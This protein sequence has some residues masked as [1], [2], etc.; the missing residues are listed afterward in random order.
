M[1]LGITASSIV[2]SS[3]GVTPDPVDWVDQ[4]GTSG[5]LTSNTQTITGITSDITIKLIIVANDTGDPNNLQY[6]KNGGLYTTYSTPFTMSNND[7]L[8]LRGINIIG[9]PGTG[10]F[11]DVVNETD[12]DTSLDIWSATYTYDI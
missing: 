5:T 1:L 2:I 12:S 6:S 8:Q 4:T 7:T 9:A 3:T 11:I 10:L